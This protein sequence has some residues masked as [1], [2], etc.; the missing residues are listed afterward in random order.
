MA[1]GEACDRG[2]RSE[3]SIMED[4]LSESKLVLFVSFAFFSAEMLEYSLY[5]S[6]E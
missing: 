5:I 6:G 2:Q 4:S 1:R 3:E